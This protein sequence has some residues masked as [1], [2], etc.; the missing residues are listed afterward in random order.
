MNT[1]C[2]NR[3]FSI[4]VMTLFLVF[5]D[6]FMPDLSAQY[7]GHNKVQYE[8]FDFNIIETD[9][10]KIYHYA[11]EGQAAEDASYMAERW[12]RRFSRLFNHE[13]KNKQ[14]LILYANHADFK[15]TNV[16]QGL[17]NQSV[18]GV[19]EGL[20]QRVVIPMTG[21][22]SE[23]N[24]VLGHELA[25]AFQY[26]IAKELGVRLSRMGRLPLFFIEGTS[27]YLSIGRGDV[28]TS[29]WMRDAVIHDDLPGIEE[30]SWNR[31]YFPYR[32]GHAFMAY[33][34][35]RL[36]D[37][38]VFDLYAGTLKN[39]WT[40][41]LETVLGDSLKAVSDD[42]RRTI[43]DEY[44]PQVKNRTHPDSLGKKVISGQEGM[45]LAPSISPDGRYLAFVSNR[46][47]FTLN[48]YLAD[49][50]SGEILDELVSSNTDAHFDALRFTN[51]SGGW[52][53]DSKKF[54]FVVFKDGDN[55]VAVL[56]VKSRD[57]EKV[58][59]FEQVDNLN[60]LAFSPDGSKIAITG[61]S[62]GVSDLYIY[63]FQ[64]ET[65][66]QLTDDRYAEIQPDWSPDGKT[67][68]FAT[69]RG[70]GTDFERLVFERMNIGLLNL[71]ENDVELLLIS[72][73]AK[74]IEPQFSADGESLY[75]VSDP[76]GF[77]N[78]YRY[79]FSEQS[80][81]KL[82][83]VATGISGLTE[84]SPTMSIAPGDNLAA[85]TVFS[86]MEY[87]IHTLDLNQV[88]ELPY[89]GEAGALAN[90]SNLPPAVYESFVNSYILAENTHRPELS[91]FH[92]NEYSPSLDLIYAGRSMLGVAVDRYGASLGGAVNLLYSDMLGNH[93]LNVTAQINGGLKDLGGQVL[94]MNRDNRINWGAMIGHI[95]Y[96]TARMFTGY[97]T[98]TVN[99]D[100]VIARE[101]ELVRERVFS[102]RA[103]LMAEYPLSQNR[104]FE[105]SS[106]YNHI[107]YDREVD[108][109]FVAGGIVV[110]R[111]EEDLEG[112]A[113]LNLWQSSLAYVGDYSFFGFTSP[114][115]GK[116]FRF[117]VEPTLGSLR[118]LTL[119]LDY[120][121]YFHFRP[122]T[123]AFRAVH[124]GRYLEDSESDRLSELYLGNETMVRG[125]SLG[126]F[127]LSECTDFN[128]EQ[129]CVEV[130]RLIGSRLAVF[131]A[132]LRLPLL[133]N[134]QYGLINFP[135]LPTELS[136]FFDGGLAWKKGQ[137]PKLDWSNESER[138]VPVFSAGVSARV[139][140][141]GYL[142]SQFYLAV[143]FQR[144]NTDTQFGFVIAPGW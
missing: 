101:Y 43:R 28:L 35:G 136:F 131:N 38:V 119:L 121:H 52:S 27:E 41:A 116:R 106:G 72:P 137:N 12:Y 39:S 75:F 57:V 120:R 110:D 67:I 30:L 84:L 140:L 123:L 45:N 65:I 69:D 115:A 81:Y 97:D 2:F 143:P 144:P 47:L 117:E 17:I 64:T 40:K 92:R 127:D 103:S 109:V 59:P 104:R 124:L 128:E 99:G 55:A 9:N 91:K 32:W 36:G 100:Q 15:Q 50:N 129:G 14:P 138:R 114:V 130:D 73:D 23:D 80:Y 141:F 93:L 3:P 77:S 142:V 133:G 98:V 113:P 6:A 61:T 85:F 88:N 74:H 83:D 108:R 94:Y 95:P 7:F 29:M 79:S 60:D 4:F 82:T 19:T 90:N 26:D 25:H 22:Y 24:H 102:E 18:G 125:Y 122:A 48:L 51:S 111:E 42:W 105:V 132:E 58:I 46:E 96:Q 20:R 21:V 31:R 68:A 76:D 37:D 78:L 66:E 33:V 112:P 87:G 16:I 86:K 135:T 63:D 139:N 56:D 13:I 54:A 1:S 5:A 10:F 70:K 126:S 118:Y 62:G 134:S 49:A 107:S 44:L 71:A 8:D 34:A 89:S 53:P 11:E